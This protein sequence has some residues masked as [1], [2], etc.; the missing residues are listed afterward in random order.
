V[1]P[2]A[3]ESTTAA[4]ACSQRGS[5]AQRQCPETSKYER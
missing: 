2:A 4:V 3:M 5:A 1:S